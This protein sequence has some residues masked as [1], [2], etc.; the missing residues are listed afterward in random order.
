[1]QEIRKINPGAKLIQTDDLGKIHST[2]LLKYQADFEN[3]RRWLSYDLLCGGV[4]EQHPLYD[5]LLASGISK[6]E[7][8][9]FRA[10][11]CNPD[12]MGFNHYIT[13][14]RY[15]DESLDVYPP[16]THGGNGRHRYAD[17]EAVRV[18]SI[19]PCGPYRLL[20][21]AWERY[22]LPMAVTEVHLYC[23]REEQMRWLSLLWNDANR[24]KEEGID[25]RAITAWA[26]LGSFGWNNL[27][28][29]PHGHYEPGVF[30][31]GTEGLRPTALAHMITAY[32]SVQQFTHPVIN[33]SGWWQRK[34]RVVYGDEH[35][36]NPDEPQPAAHQPVLITGKT[37]TLGNAF[38]RICAA[39]G[40]TYKILD[41]NELDI[42][43][44]LEIE[45]VILANNP[46]AI[47]NTAGFV[48]V[49]DAE[50]ESR[51]CF[52]VNTNG[53]E[54]LAIL[55]AKYNIKLLTYST[56]LVF[57]GCKTNPY[58]EKDN[59]SPLSI[60]GQSK[61]QAEQKVLNHHPTALI[62]RTSAFFG[63][64]DNYNFLKL[65]I[66]NL[67][68]GKIFKV[69]SDV[70]VSPTYVPDLVH[71]SLDLLIDDEKGIWHLTNKGQIVWSHLAYS[72]VDRLQ[73]STHL[74]EP[75]PLNALGYKA[76]RPFYS[77]L[78]SDRGAILPTLDN[79]IDR[80]LADINA[81]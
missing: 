15:L 14:E 37:G 52:A 69:A 78:G 21:E 65:I 24:L 47:V 55:C 39:R 59:I 64:W 31:L 5:Y 81:A 1:M 57:N 56:D 10:N 74:I 67:R 30:D 9:F 79:A 46:W 70:M 26:L 11:K 80:C 8:Q 28:T 13:S 50:T 7:L 18:G 63:P 33:N 41:R 17:V 6:I 77:V 27:L 34:C 35:F 43:N 72:I 62:I 68:S 25:I 53:P 32:N 40:I 49:D 3:D 16:H 73:L 71:T 66:E 2:P 20:S 4:N 22:H 61:A 75:V 38:A 23:T 76:Q 48:N 42:T 58:T 12:I 45:K 36:F 60:Y 19:C 54:N 44:A 51:S 29:R